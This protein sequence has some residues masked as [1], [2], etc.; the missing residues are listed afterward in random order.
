MLHAPTP[1][2]VPPTYPPRPGLGALQ[3]FLDDDQIS[4]GFVLTC[5]AYPQSDVVIATHREEELL[6]S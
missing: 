2:A 3:S 5:Y 6:S 4:K 1:K